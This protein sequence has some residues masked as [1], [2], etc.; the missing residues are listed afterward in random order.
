[1]FMF[2]KKSFAGL[3]KTAAV[4]LAVCM[5]AGLFTCLTVITVSADEPVSTETAVF[6]GKTGVEKQAA[7][8][9]PVDIPHPTENVSL[10]DDEEQF[11]VSFKCKMLSGSKPAIGVYDVDDSNNRAWARPSWCDQNSVV[12]E[13][14]VCTA[15]ISV[16][17]HRRVDPNGEGY[18][19]FYL[20]IGN[21]YYNGTETSYG[22]FDDSFILS[23][24]KL[25]WYDSDEQALDVDDE[26]G[27]PIDRLENATINFNGTYFFKYDGCDN[28]DSPLGASAMQWHVLAAPDYV[29]K[30]TVPSD[31]NTSDNYGA[32]NFVKT[33]ETELTREY[34]TNAAYEGKYF[35]A[36]KNSVGEGFEIISDINKKMVIIDA[37]HEGE[38]DINNSD[39]GVT[40]GA[41]GAPKY[42]RAANIFLPISYGQYAMTGSTAQNIS[43]LVKIT[44]KAVRLEGDSAPVIGRIVGKKGNSSGKGSQALCKAA[45]NIPEGNYA[46]NPADYNEK[47][48]DSES[49]RL[50]CEYN[51]ETGEFT[52]WMRVRCADNDYSSRF[53]CNEV[54]TIGNAEH[55]WDAGGKFDSTSFNSSF[56]ISNVKVDLYECGSGYVRGEMIAEDIAPHLYADTL[57]TTSRWAYQYRN[58]GSY[59]CSNNNYDCIRAPQKLWSA[60]GNVGMVHTENLT[61]CMAAGH[62]VTH[63]A[64]AENTREYWACSCGKNFADPYGKTE[65][66]DLSAKN[67]MIYIA[68]SEHPATAFIPIKL[69]G[70]ENERWFK[71]TCKCKLIGGESVPVVSTL[72]NQYYGQNECLTTKPGDDMA[73]AEYSYDPET[74][75]LTAYIFGWIKDIIGQKDRYPFERMNA[76]SGANVAILIGNGR[77]I[78]AGYDEQNSD[79]DYAIAEPELYML[80]CTEGASGL[81]SAKAA[82]TVSSNLITPITNRTVD[83]EKEYV[84]T[85]TNA[86][87]PLSAQ[88][89]KWY[90]TGKDQ[91][92][93]SARTLPA[94][95][96]TDGFVECPHEH[97][98]VEPAVAST[99]ITQ[100]HAEHVYCTDCGEVIEGSEDALPLDPNNHTN[101]DAVGAAEPTC[102]ESGW[103]GVQTCLDCGTVISAE[104]T[105]IPALGHTGGIATC[106]TKAICTRCHQEYGEF[107]ANNHDGETELR[108][109]VAATADNPEGYTG[110]TYCLG[111]NEKIATGKPVYYDGYKI[112]YVLDGGIN[113][114]KNPATYAYDPEN[115]LPIYAATKTNYTFDGWYTDKEYSHKT[116]IIPHGYSRD[117]T[118]YAKWICKHADTEIKNAKAA[119]CTEAGYT[120]DT[121]CKNCGAR[122]ASGTAVKA[123]G[124]KPSDWK[125][126]KA[127]AIGVAGSK[128][129][130]CTVCKAVLE[131]AT[132]DALPY[133]TY[134]ITYKL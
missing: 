103:T 68:A 33:E 10:F 70:F 108:D 133:P 14:G 118:L 77:Y 49:N 67:Q 35:A 78:G 41:E 60:E 100:G 61:A 126:V 66:Y 17:F 91:A 9:I 123:L 52:G 79:T 24:I 4:F 124:H 23:D 53:G 99:C 75:T 73:V 125:V 121:Y 128:Q 63:H 90:R 21:S 98:A 129:K 105:E 19:S 96:F 112:T 134:T 101:I 85:W 65:I 113:S 94:D 11:Q 71:F 127:A 32:S 25:V 13:D 69:S 50:K 36:L 30:I 28:W 48:Y 59:N 88:Q 22:D 74:Y 38:A 64:A 93:V 114:D 115:D 57:D 8:F 51:A 130:V 104:N 3:K 84:A 107:D 1:M 119:T 117:I 46:T 89:G 5:L 120:G 18:R 76:V 7:I 12:I 132:I 26:T 27:K 56:A 29:K 72:Y 110:D 34:Y 37:N 81:A 20:V 111:C 83:F 97:T 86:N 6:I 116:D 87:N 39:D 92:N 109:V 106:H 58:D 43:F 131:T 2:S 31:Y 45:Y 44:F 80:D 15:M 95:Y 47:Y 54:I 62:T 122:T 102:T 16:N 82:E 55:V 40:P 42:N